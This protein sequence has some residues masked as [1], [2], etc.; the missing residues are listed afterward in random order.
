MSQSLLAS[1]PPRMAGRTG[2]AAEPARAPRKT[3]PP[4]LAGSRAP[5]AQRSQPGGD[6]SVTPGPRPLPAWRGGQATPQRGQVGTPELAQPLLAFISRLTTRACSI[7][8]SESTSAT[9]CQLAACFSQPAGLTPNFLAR[10]A[11]RI[12]TFISPN[13]GS[14]LIL[15]ARS[16]P[17]RA[18][19]HTAAASPPY[20]FTTL[21]HGAGTRGA[22][23]PGNRWSAV[24]SRNTALS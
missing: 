17:S 19:V 24:R 10:T 18:P 11:T 16:S 20:S 9:V 23:L 2:H 21:W 8:S 4:R 1:P 3:S 15:A 7:V 13:P 14:F 6:V 5:S 12:F 22:M